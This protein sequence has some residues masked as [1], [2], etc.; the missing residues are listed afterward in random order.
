MRQREADK[1]ENENELKRA[2]ATS[3][4]AEE[5]KGRKI[6]VDTSSTKPTR[7]QRQCCRKST[8]QR[9]THV[10]Q[11]AWVLALVALLFILRPDE[12]LEK[13]QLFAIRHVDSEASVRHCEFA[14]FGPN[15]NRLR[16]KLAFSGLSSLTTAHCSASKCVD[17]LLNGGWQATAFSGLRPSCWISCPL[18]L[19]TCTQIVSS[20]SQQRWGL[21]FGSSSTS[22][23]FAAALGSGKGSGEGESLRQNGLPAL[24]YRTTIGILS[25]E[26]GF[27]ASV[28][29]IASAN[30]AVRSSK[31]MEKQHQSL[32]LEMSGISQQILSSGKFAPRSRTPQRRH[33]SFVK[34]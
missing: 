14:V 15:A 1:F 11:I 21:I 2:K 33:V 20:A 5:T 12:E 6:G 13:E 25:L 19:W 9:V 30:A 10:T 31:L 7:Q 34:A 8:L 27:C 29:G 23:T 17:P 3:S 26:S 16:R 32:R 24:V 4:A 28:S 22:L 18:W